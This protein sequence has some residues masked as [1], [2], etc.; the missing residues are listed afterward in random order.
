MSK[1]GGSVHCS[2]CPSALPTLPRAWHAKRLHS[3]SDAQTVLQCKAGYGSAADIPVAVHAQPVARLLVELR[4]H[5]RQCRGKTLHGSCA[6]LRARS[7]HL[8]R[9]AR[10]ARR[11]TLCHTLA[12]SAKLTMLC[13]ML[14]TC[15]ALNSSLSV[16]GATICAKAGFCSAAKPH[17]VVSCA[18][19]RRS[20][21]AHA[22]APPHSAGPHCARPDGAMPR[23]CLLRRRP[24]RLSH[25]QSVPPPQPHPAPHAR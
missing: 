21:R 8:G 1:T 2:S 20:P 10:S 15:V 13:P 24:H 6:R 16:G 18:P 22:P 5:E 9:N 23:G 25:H 4:T 11:G 12:V 3:H 14:I 7:V 17:K 19:A